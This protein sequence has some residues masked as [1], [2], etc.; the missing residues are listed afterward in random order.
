M[1]CYVIIHNATSNLNCTLIFLRHWS[2]LYVSYTSVTK[3]KFKHESMKRTSSEIHT[4]VETIYSYGQGQTLIYDC[5]Y[6]LHEEAA[7][8]FNADLIIRQTNDVR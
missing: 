4:M 2:I 3:L 1:V 7:I 8:N 5:V 6:S